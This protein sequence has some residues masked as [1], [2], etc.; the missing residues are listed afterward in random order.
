MRVRTHRKRIPLK[1]SEG[2]IRLV[3]GGIS[4]HFFIFYEFRLD[5]LQ[6]YKKYRFEFGSIYPRLP[7]I[8]S[9][10]EDEK[11]DSTELSGPLP[12]MDRNEVILRCAGV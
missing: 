3:Q 5:S 12:A 10:N 1:K 2:R 11:S 6:V 9:G 4:L 8:I 7:V